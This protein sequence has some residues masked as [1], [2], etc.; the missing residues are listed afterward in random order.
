MILVFSSSTDF[1]H[2]F[3]TG[4]GTPFGSHFLL[5]T[6]SSEQ[7]SELRVEIVI[8][9]GV[10]LCTGAIQIIV[11]FGLRIAA[12]N[13]I[14]SRLVVFIQNTRAIYQVRMEQIERKN[15]KIGEN[16]ELR[17]IIEK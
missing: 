1:I 2:S 7:A 16:Q 6:V 11:D 9:V 10:G 13:V 8:S 14:S 3:Q 12:I 15:V 4:S 5:S 17:N